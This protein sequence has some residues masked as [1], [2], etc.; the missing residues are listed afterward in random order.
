MAGGASARVKR[1]ASAT[2]RHPC[3]PASCPA[4]MP[5]VARAPLVLAAG[6]PSG[7]RSSRPPGRPPSQSRISWSVVPPSPSSLR[8]SRPSLAA[9]L[10]PNVRSGRAYLTAIH[11][12]YAL[13]PLSSCLRDALPCPRR[14][15]WRL[16]R[17]PRWGAARS[18][19]APRPIPAAPSARPRPGRRG[20]RLCPSR[21]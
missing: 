10:R 20:D 7:A 1:G 12:S 13:P 11:G 9:P 21:S 15:P 6:P 14:P 3:L 17:R 16:S 5:G 4:S 2:V 18:P 8:A 19:P